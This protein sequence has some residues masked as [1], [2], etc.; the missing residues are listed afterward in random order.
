MVSINPLVLREDESGTTD[1]EKKQD[2][3]Y[4]NDH[5]KNGHFGSKEHE[6][7]TFH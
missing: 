6:T 2:G 7:M 1:S 4:S 5:K 3:H